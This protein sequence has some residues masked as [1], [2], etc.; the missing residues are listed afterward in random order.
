MASNRGNIRF[1]LKIALASTAVHKLRAVLAV[2]GVFLGALAF[3]GVQHASLAMVKKAE[4]ETE[5]LGPN[6][7]MAMAGQIRMSR[8]GGP[9]IRSS[10]A[11]TF[12]QEDATTLSVSCRSCFF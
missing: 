12:T 7:F 8:G 1:S 6:L 5:K 11:R 2:L 10:G 9:V 3:T 4:L